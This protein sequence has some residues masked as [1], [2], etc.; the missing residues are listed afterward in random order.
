[1]SCRNVSLFLNIAASLGL[2]ASTA[3]SQQ[4]AQCTATFSDCA[5][6]ENTLLGFPFLAIS[7][8]VAVVP[9]LH[10]NV[11]ATSDVFRIANNFVDTGRGTGIG[12][13]GY[14]FSGQNVLP[15]PST[16]S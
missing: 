1:M 13:L 8:D 12:F 2:A 10:S 9:N 11:A 14:L 7:G 3:Y 15:S 16:Y 6:P 5:V 4:P